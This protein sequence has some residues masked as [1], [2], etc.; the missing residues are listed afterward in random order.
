MQQDRDDLLGESAES[1]FF[2]LMR[3]RVSRKK[4]TFN[5]QR[6]RALGINALAAREAAALAEQFMKIARDEGLDTRPRDPSSEALQ[7]CLLA[8]FPDMVALRLDR[9]TLR[10][11]LVHGRRGVLARE[12]VVT[13]RCS[14]PAK[15]AKSRFAGKWRPA[16]AG[17]G[18][19][20]GLAARAFSRGLYRRGG[21]CL[22]LRAAPRDRQAP[23][24]FSR[25]R[26]AERLSDE[27]PPEEAAALLAREVEAGNCPLK[28]W[29]HAVEQWIMR[30]NL[31]AEWAPE[32]ELPQAPQ[33]RSHHAPGANL[34]RRDKLSR[35]QGARRL[36]GGKVVAFTRAAGVLDRLAP[37]RLELP[38]GRAF[39][40]IYAENSP[41]TIAA[42]IQDLYGVEGD[43]RIAAGKVPLV[44]QVLAPNHRPIQITTNLANFWNE[45][46]RRSNRSCSANIRS[47]SG[48]EP[49]RA[50]LRCGR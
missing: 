28:H 49:S 44:I 39:K 5:P 4:R 15:C 30:L 12:S 45:S 24:A 25:S 41:P 8:G 13:R 43:L 48:A 10:C 2:L 35:D 22:R 1:D 47:T 11:A 21:G 9:G 19:R 6:C 50:L 42:R 17:D 40:I 23:H 14:W 16:H 33:G 34:P 27:V 29:D 3:A 26:S 36:A 32:Y 20:R 37:E 7:R 18:D 38:N 46:T 31:L